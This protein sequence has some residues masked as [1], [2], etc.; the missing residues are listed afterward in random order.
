MKRIIL[1][2]SILFG[3]SPLF[4]Q[5]EAE[6]VLVFRNTGEVNLFYTSELDSIAL[7]AYDKDSVLHDEMVSQLFYANDTVVSIPIAEIDSV[8]FGSRNVMEM[9]SG[10]KELT[11]DIDL[12]WIIRFDGESIY[13]RLNT[14]VSILPKTG[15]RLF[16]GLND[17][18]PETAI[19]PY[20]L[21]ARA[22]SI[23]VQEN[24][25]KVDVEMVGLEEIF[26][27]LF[28]AGY[29][30]EENSTGVKRRADGREHGETYQEL[31][32]GVDIKSEH[33]DID[34]HGTLS[35][36]GPFVFNPFQR[37][38]HVDL[39][40][41]FKFNTDVK[42]H[43]DENAEIEYESFDGNYT[44]IASIYRVLNINGAVG[45]FAD[46]NASLD[47]DF[48]FERS[49]KRK[50][51]WDRRGNEQTWTFPEVNEQGEATNKAK[52]E[53]L[54]DGRL[55]FG[56]IAGIEIVTVGDLLGARAK[57]KG[58]PEI[59]GKINLGMIREMHDYNPSFYGQAKLDIC[60]KLSLEGFVLNREHLLW[61]P[62]I[63][64]KVAEFNSVTGGF[65][66]N[67]FPDYTQTRGVQANRRDET[68]VSVATKVE[69][70]IAHELETGFEV[71][72]ANDNVVDSVFNDI[73]LADTTVIQ[74]F[75]TEFDLPTKYKEEKLRIQPVFH[76]AG[77]TVA[78]EPVSVS[79]DMFI[80]M[81]VFSG[82]NGCVSYL[83]GIPFEGTAFDDSTLYIAGPYMPVHV[84]DTIFHSGGTFIDDA[85]VYI[86][87]EKEMN[88]I[89]IWTG[90]EGNED[91]SYQF[92]EDGTGN[93]NGGHSFTYLVN[94]PQSG[95][96]IIY[97]DEKDM[98][99]RILRIVNI[100][101][102][103]LNYHLGNE[104]T[105]N[106]LNKLY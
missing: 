95:R 98:E 68:E 31:K 78:A 60:S 25:I 37:Y 79:K 51:Q 27:R 12:P 24:E 90:K 52:I 1:F 100:T 70:V 67:L 16:Y 80:Q 42:L 106:T 84:V 17:D 9:R 91:V 89:G 34:I 55:Y 56:P 40:V 63:E 101:E 96:I 48:G 105:I 81:F 104:S 66:W 92:K 57:V 21:T 65:T 7:S 13:Y 50:L 39:D 64:H 74:G 3:F 59:E 62:V 36:N 43:A 18:N 33:G 54:L 88:L 20:G 83:S 53:L 71:I 4:A 29:L 93:F 99:T 61:G 86:E 26:N 45:A 46:M 23:Q 69:N 28:F 10:V 19:F 49:Y 14:P 76:Y 72:D 5:E 82:N 8:A 11:K 58:G 103:T 47:L 32:I 15:D 102:T 73:V 85:D 6:Q 44:P 75:T 30:H 2:I 87:K 41:E 38:E 97:F 35:V 77:H 94:Q 22:M